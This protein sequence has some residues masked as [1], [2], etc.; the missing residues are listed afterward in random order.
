METTQSQLLGEKLLTQAVRAEGIESLPPVEGDPQQIWDKLL[1]ITGNRT[2]E[3]LLMDL[4][5]GKRIA[6][7]VAKLMVSL[8]AEGG[9]RRD[10]LLMTRERFTPQEG[11]AHA[12]VVIDGSENASVQLA[13]CCRP[14][15]GDDILGYL[16]RGEGLLVH[17]R[18]CG[19]AK[20]LFNKD[21]ERFLPV[22]WSDE[23][24]RAFETA[25]SVTVANGKGVLARVAAALAHAEVD[26][27]HIDM[28]QEAAQ[29]TT[30]LKFLVAVRD[31]QHMDTA[32]RDLR[33]TSSVVR[34][35]RVSGHA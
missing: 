3:E 16:G 20:R 35:E 10:A 27:V 8:M 30:E 12:G 26:I 28:G 15:P 25:I 13:H 11:S 23:P 14:V 19:I 34:A 7:I 9:A 24:V 18:E 4:G 5:L 21:A 6:T 2:R 22:E 17:S 1:R 33:R 31:R 29:A 32:L